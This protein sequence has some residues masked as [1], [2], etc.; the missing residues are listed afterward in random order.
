MVQTR[1]TTDGAQTSQSQ[2]QRGD[3]ILLVIPRVDNTILPTVLPKGGVDS[4][5]NDD[6][7]V[8]GS[9]SEL[10]K[11]RLENQALQLLLRENLNKSTL[12]NEDD[13]EV[14]STRWIVPS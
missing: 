9:Q 11:L 3:G 4:N 13:T 14:S 6:I 12:Q 5:Y 1:R 7:A 8:D 2:P 10:T